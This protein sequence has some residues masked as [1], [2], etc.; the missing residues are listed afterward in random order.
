[1]PNVSKEACDARLAFR[2]A[3]HWCLS[4]VYL[5]AEYQAASE[6]RYEAY[7][8][9]RDLGLL[10]PA[11]GNRVDKLLREDLLRIWKRNGLY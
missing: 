6:L 7:E 11:W 8:R 3:C 4:T 1:M 2:Q 10:N 5:P 9:L